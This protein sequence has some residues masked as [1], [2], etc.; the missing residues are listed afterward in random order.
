MTNEAGITHQSAWD[1]TVN[2]GSMGSFQ[3]HQHAGGYSYLHGGGNARTDV[4][5]GRRMAAADIRA[6][7][8]SA[9]QDLNRGFNNASGA[10]SRGRDDAGRSISQ[11]FKDASG[12]I[13][14]GRDDAARSIAA[15]QRF[16][17]NQIRD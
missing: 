4:A 14:R 6:G 2:R 11:G 8:Q 15:G 17:A 10:I 13:S 12:A 9:R 16:G 7:T 3:D 5:A 1:M